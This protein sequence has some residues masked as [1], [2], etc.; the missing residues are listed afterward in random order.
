[1]NRRFWGHLWLA[2]TEDPPSPVPA[3][4]D[5]E[6]LRGHRSSW[7]GRREAQEQGIWS[8]SSAVVAHSSRSNPVSPR[9]GIVD[10]EVGM[11]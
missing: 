6:G 3:S 5:S 11:L 10:S 4:H 8:V 2:L 1:M 7:E 9:A